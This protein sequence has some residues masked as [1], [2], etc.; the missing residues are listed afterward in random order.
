MFNQ[1]GSFFTRVEI[2]SRILMV[3]PPMFLIAKVIQSEG[4]AKVKKN[5]NE[6]YKPNFERIVTNCLPYFEKM[7]KQKLGIEE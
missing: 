1:D 4:D 3:K 6:F 2:Q 7:E 5:F